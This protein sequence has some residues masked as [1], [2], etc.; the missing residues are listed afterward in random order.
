[1][2]RLRRR[3]FGIKDQEILFST[4]GFAMGNHDTQ[5]RLE[6]VGEC[7]VLGYHIALEESFADPLNQR[8][9][10]VAPD[11]R[12]FAFEGAGMALALQDMIFPTQQR[13]R[14]FLNSVAFSHR[15]LVIIGAGW[16]LGRTWIQPHVLRSRLDPLLGW[17]VIDGYGFHNAYF[18]TEKTVVQQIIPRKIRGY[19]RRV[20]DQGIGRCL[21]FIYCADVEAIVNAIKNFPI[22]RQSDLW[23]GVGLACAYAGGAGVNEVAY[24][25]QM[26]GIYRPM[27]AQGAAFAAKARFSG[28]N[29]NIEME[30]AIPILCDISAQ[31]A[32]DV[33][34]RTLINLGIGTD[35]LP[36]YERWRQRIQ[37]TFGG[38]KDEMDETSRENN[39]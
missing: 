6:H 22:T 34:D 26:S 12:G 33:T 15:Y 9:R 36:T 7:F 3:L 5:K 30:K 16:T 18:H 4:R 24:L 11:F 35:L 39:P 37:C 38:V 21:W 14:P 31:E 23:S 27:L 1:M 2:K 10:E 20:F 28:G 19:E 25:T 8:L 17:L 29:P 13:L 32:A